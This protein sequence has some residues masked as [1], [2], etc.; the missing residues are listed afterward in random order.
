VLLD[1]DSR[2]DF[3]TL[4]VPGQEHFLCSPHRPAHTVA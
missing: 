3:D 2:K 4:S 1:P